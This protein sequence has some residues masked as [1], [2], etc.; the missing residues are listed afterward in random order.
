MPES[1]T[2]ELYRIYKPTGNPQGVGVPATERKD[3]VNANSNLF[4]VG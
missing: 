4:K 3:E 1:V 2:E